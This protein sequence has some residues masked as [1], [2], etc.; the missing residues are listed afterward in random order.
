MS[1][2]FLLRIDSVDILEISIE[3]ENTKKFRSRN[4]IY[5]QALRLGLPLLYKTVFGRRK[6]PSDADELEAAKSDDTKKIDAMLQELSVNSYILE[7]LT[8]TIYNALLEHIEGGKVSK[9]FAAA[10]YYAQLPENMQE[11]KD[12]LLG[13]LKR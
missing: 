12:E 8:T 4:E 7:Y 3:I 5:N 1:N 6:N 13:K 9:E 10:G 11:I 2:K